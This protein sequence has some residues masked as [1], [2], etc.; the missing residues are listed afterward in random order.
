MTLHKFDH[1]VTIVREKISGRTT[2]P[3]RR[4][5]GREHGSAN[6]FGC[7]AAL[8]VWFLE[9]TRLRQPIDREAIPRLF[10]WGSILDKKL[11]LSIDS[12]QGQQIIKRLKVGTKEKTI[13]TCVSQEKMHLQT[14]GVAAPPHLEIMALLQG[15]GDEIK[16]LPERLQQAK[17]SNE[18]QIEAF[19]TSVTMGF[20]KMEKLIRSSSMPQ[21]QPIVGTE[22]EKF[23]STP[24]SI[25]PAPALASPK[26]GDANAFALIV[27]QEIIAPD[28]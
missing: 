19:T 10:R 13:T 21:D 25:T 23:I 15:I 2:T 6:I 22:A 17:S 4:I 24:Q 28:P 11:S 27:D 9:H 7:S 20:N 5:G 3:K 26:Y 8:A 1:F 16:L 14:E 18:A 12:L